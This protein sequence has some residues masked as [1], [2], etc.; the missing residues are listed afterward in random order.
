MEIP[1][2]I[3]AL[4]KGVGSRS[5]TRNKGKGIRGYHYAFYLTEESHP[6]HGRN[7][8]QI[9]HSSIFTGITQCGSPRSAENTCFLQ[10]LLLAGLFA[11]RSSCQ[12]WSNCIEV[13]PSCLVSQTSF[14]LCF[15]IGRYCSECKAGARE[16]PS[17]FCLSQAVSPKITLVALASGP[18][19]STSPSSACVWVISRLVNG[20]LSIYFIFAWTA[21]QPF[22]W[23]DLV[24]YSCQIRFQKC[25][26][27]N[28]LAMPNTHFFPSTTK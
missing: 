1:G 26:L 4:L 2:Q 6:T 3:P 24:A 10:P 12:L 9:S 18:R 8:W 22:F 17:L 27:I 28:H 19:Y 5:Y 20:L 13:G 25:I 14:S 16:M 23:C 21:F 7:T 11:H 15:V